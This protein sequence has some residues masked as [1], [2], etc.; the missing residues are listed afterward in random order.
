MPNLAEVLKADFS[1]AGQSK[2]IAER[3]GES[4]FQSALVTLIERPDLVLTSEQW[5]PIVS[6]AAAAV[7][8]QAGKTISSGDTL[9]ARDRVSS[10]VK[11]PFVHA[12]AKA[13]DGNADM[14]LTGNFGESEVLGEVARNVLRHVAR[15]TPEDAEL[16]DFFS[17]KGATLVFE[18]SLEVIAS[19]PELLVKGTSE[20]DAYIRQFLTSVP[21]IIVGAPRPFNS[22]ELATD[23]AVVALEIAR[24][25]SV[26]QV[27][28]DPKNK[29]W[30]AVLGEISQDLI[31]TIFDGFSDAIKQTGDDRGQTIE[32][33]FSSLF[34]RSQA[35]LMVRTIARHVAG[36]P[37]LLVGDKASP[38]IR[39]LSLIHI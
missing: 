31:G 17:P 4:L 24:D 22:K 29:N 37:G 34:S 11:G 7:H 28:S 15:L 1:A 39:N 38:E 6:A 12:I 2:S 9:F 36:T 35:V 14:V 32:D 3:V 13:V 30:D 8:D 10:F 20:N 18:K 21:S 19:R 27:L 25:Y 5:R 16:Y 33:L 23:L 26:A